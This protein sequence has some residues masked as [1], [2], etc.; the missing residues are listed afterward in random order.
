M[1]ILHTS[2]WHIGHNLYGKSR[3]EE[4]EAFFDWLI[5]C[6][7]R[8]RI[9][10]LIVSGDIFDTTNPS[11]RSLE[12]YYRFLWRLSETDCRYAIITGGN[13]DSPSLL[14]APKEILRCMDLHIFGAVTD[15]ISD[16]IV[17]LNNA[18]G[19]PGAVVCAVPYLRDRDIR[20]YKPGQD[21]EEKGLELIAAIGE[22]YRRIADEA[23]KTVEKSGYDL[24]VIATGHLF[25]AGGMTTE[26]DGVRD[27]YVGKLSA[28]SPSGFPDTF[29]YVA[30]GHLH[31]PQK[32]G[33]E[34]I[35][36]SG[37][38]L[39]I[40]F[41]EAKR[42]KS[43]VVAD[44]SSGK[45]PVI[46]EIT[47]PCFM[48]L[49]SL[50]GDSAEITDK[51][52]DLIFAAEKCCVEIIYVGRA[53]AVEVNRRFTDMVKD[54]PVDILRIKNLQIARDSEASC[55]SCITLEDLDENEVFRR[56]LAVNDVSEEDYGELLS[57]YGEILAEIHEG[58]HNAE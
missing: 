57:A 56:C 14:N 15:E 31:M 53:S 26:G 24:P 45:T 20:R 1:R 28:F 42:R 43:V 50:Q 35:R 52:R 36:Y 44:F 17:V 47:V 8:E 11:N 51:L 9:E 3:Y 39:P 13:H 41:C 16:H 54:T 58:D 38:P 22:F 46:E 6:I 49:Y 30:L 37:A 40:G 12:I 48:P 10:A 5:D 4:F 55:D 29:D 27:I 34:H 33:K 32:S 21:A 18:E 7:D 23:E 19:N 2:D 25:A